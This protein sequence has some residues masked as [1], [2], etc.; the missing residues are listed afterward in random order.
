M[1]KRRINFE[2]VEILR[3]RLGLTLMEFCRTHGIDH[4]TY[5]GLA[6]GGGVKDK[7]IIKL[8]KALDIDPG[9]ILIFEDHE[10]ISA[11]K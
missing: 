11:Q 6:N 5:S 10:A 4:K 2:K 7:T 8:S 1:V 3:L 9:E